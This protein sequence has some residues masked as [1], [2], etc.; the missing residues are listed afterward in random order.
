LNRAKYFIDTFFF[1]LDSNIVFI[2]AGYVAHKMGVPLELVAAVNPNDIVYRALLSADFSLRNR[3][4]FYTY[5]CKK[6]HH[7]DGAAAAKR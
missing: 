3:D 6:P 7:F 5:T 2:T 1:D 4:H